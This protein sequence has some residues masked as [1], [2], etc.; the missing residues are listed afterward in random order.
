MGLGL[1]IFFDGYIGVFYSIL[2]FEVSIRDRLS[3]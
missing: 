1:E 2:G 3:S